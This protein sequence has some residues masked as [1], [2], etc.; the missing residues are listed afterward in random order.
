MSDCWFA[1][2]PIDADT[3]AIS[4]PRHWE[5]T[6]SYLLCGQERALLIDTGLGVADMGEAVRRLTKLPVLAAVTHAH[7]DHIG[8][9]GCFAHTAVH[10]A[11][12]GWVSGQFPLPLQIVRDN[13]TARPCRFPEGFCP[14]DY[15]VYSDGAG[16]RLRDGE[17][18][19]LGGR[20]VQVLHTPGHSP[21]HCC[22]YEAARGFLFA[23]DL[24]YAGCLDA[25]YPT[26]DPQQFARSVE[27]ICH[28]PVARILPGHHRMDLPPDFAARV[29]AA[30]QHLE[31]QGLLRQGSGIFSFDGFQIHL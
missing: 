23:G 11:E 30:W 8:G 29:N 27:R 16:E 10:E 7:W 20:Q 4:E 3:Y 31:R 9:L 12:A 17:I 2:E 26:T 21:G 14:E 13:L 22:F 1:V 25:F 24:L 19:D 18:I 28:L 15:S 6:H 5:E